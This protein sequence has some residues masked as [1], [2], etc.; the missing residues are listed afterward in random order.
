MQTEQAFSL[1]G[2]PTEQTMLHDPSSKK[3]TGIALG[4]DLP[5]AKEVREG[6]RLEA[7]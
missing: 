6:G 3:R 2:E 4:F 7:E 5:E 1:L